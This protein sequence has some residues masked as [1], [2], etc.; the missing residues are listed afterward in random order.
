MKKFLN[1]DIQVDGVGMSR[2]NVNVFGNKAVL[3]AV[4][5]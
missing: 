2:C 1:T 4:M 5:A 3:G